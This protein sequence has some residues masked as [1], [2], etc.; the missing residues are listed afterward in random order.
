MNPA[1]ERVTGYRSEEVL[2][3]QSAAPPERTPQPGL[4]RDDVGNP[5]RRTALGRRRGEPAQGRRPVHRGERDLARPRRRRY[6][7]R[8]RGREARRHARAHRP[9]QGA[10]TDPGARAD[11]AGARPAPSRRR[12]RKRRRMPSA[13]RSSGCRRPTSRSCSPSTPTGG[14][15]RSAPRRPAA[16]RSRT[17]WSVRHGRVTSARAR[18]KGRGWKAGGRSNDSRS[19][20]NSAISTSARW[21]S[22]RSG[23]SRTWWACSSW[24]QPGRTRPTGLPSASRP[25]SSSPRSPSAVLGPSMASR[26]QRSRSRELLQATID[27]TAFHPVFQPIIDL[28]SLG[29]IGYE[30]L[31]RFDDGT[32]PGHPVHDRGGARAR[33]RISRSRRSGRH[34]PRPRRSRR[35]RGST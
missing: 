5:A 1:F 21:P 9:G 10:G 12:R 19:A 29:V 35:C 14:R 30:A 13:T 11:R 22:R 23:S 31:T 17:G 3:Q 15:A 33:R 7:H 26:V 28:R 4:L 34:W 8:V 27:R 32:R 25:W 24:A 18:R 20:R 2:G 16:A 6:D